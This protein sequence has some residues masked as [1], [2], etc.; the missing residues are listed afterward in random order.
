MRKITKTAINKMRPGRH[1]LGFGLSVLVAR[2]G[3]RQYIWRG[4]VS[5]GQP[6]QVS[7]GGC[8]LCSPDEAMATALE[9]KRSA[10]KGRDPVAATSTCPTLRE[11]SFRT[12][13]TLRPNWKKNPARSA[14]DFERIVSAVRFYSRPVDSV[15]V[16]DCSTAIMGA[17]SPTVSALLSRNLTHIFNR[18]VAEGHR[19]DNPAK[20][21]Q[22][23][24]PKIKHETVHHA[25]VGYEGVRGMLAKVENSRAAPV[26][27]LILR[28]LALTGL[29][30][31]EGAEMLWSEID[32]DAG[33]ATIGAERMKMGREFKLPLSNEA[34]RVLK[35]ARALGDGPLVF[36]TAKGQPISRNALGKLLRALDVAGTVHGLRSA[37]RDWAS[38]TTTA[39]HE[40][41]E[42]LLAHEV[43]SATVKA[44]RRT[45]FYADRAELLEQWASYIAADNVTTLKAA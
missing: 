1:S 29:R 34:L 23:L 8:A 39:S 24:M 26:T 18:A 37:L 44:Y 5:G 11:V 40:C 36:P 27:R 10:R 2:G 42:M 33:M 4:T 21:A 32:M 7:M 20:A 12:M 38:D 43:G 13:E 16:A 17:Q 35:A 25:T 30:S 41:A 19:D 3:S 9:Y 22:A 6:V 31:R 15:T 45:D 14:A 28:F